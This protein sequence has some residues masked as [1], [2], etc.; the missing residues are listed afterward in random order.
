[1]EKEK[2]DA[3]KKRKQTPG[4]DEVVML[5]TPAKCRAFL[6]SLRFPSD[7]GKPNGMDQATR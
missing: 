4:G 2:K 6:K 1:M 7:D 3:M 5:D